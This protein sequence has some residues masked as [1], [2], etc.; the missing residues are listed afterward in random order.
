MWT[1]PKIAPM[2]TGGVIIKIR[3]EST[4]PRFLASGFYGPAMRVGPDGEPDAARYLDALIEMAAGRRGDHVFF[5][6]QNRFVYGG[7]LRGASD[8]AAI[9]LNGRRGLLG[10][11]AN[12][13][14]V[15]PES[16]VEPSEPPR[17]EGL[18]SA[19]Q[20]RRCR[21]LFVRF[22]DE[23]GLAGRWIDEYE[24]Y[25][26]L[27]DYAYLLPT[28]WMN[29]GMVAISPGETNRL[30]EL[31]RD[32]PS[33][34][35]GHDENDVIDRC[36]EPIPHDPDYGPD[37]L[38]ARTQEGL[39]AAALADPSQLSVG[40]PPRGASIAQRVPISPFRPRDV[41]FADVGWY[42]GRSINGGTLPDVL[43]YLDDEPAGAALR[44]RIDIQQ[45]WL[46]RLLGDGARAIDRFVAAPAFEDGFYE[47]EGEG[48][49]RP[50][51][52][53]RLPLDRSGL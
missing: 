47:S 5:R 52:E 27:G 9:S 17:F 42:T 35:I 3:N 20:T 7:Q 41:E 12:A 33:G 8:H 37:L 51:H 4:I 46:E 43:L 15:I 44:H 18:D 34:V 30:I 32:D 22:R 45:A 2:P 21:P 25:F 48:T 49:M 50:S 10:K 28:T 16:G 24:L 53:I 14:C 26:A 19:R 29:T 11:R 23:L 39:L 6:T 31:V 13:P 1:D 38:G 36:E 40:L